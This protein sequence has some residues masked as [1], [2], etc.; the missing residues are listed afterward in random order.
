MDYNPAI[1]I[2]L[3]YSNLINKIPISEFLLSIPNYIWSIIYLVFLAIFIFYSIVLFFHWSSYRAYSPLVIVAR[4][5]YLVG[6]LAL[7]FL[8]GTFLINY[9]N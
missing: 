2:D 5:V 1:L 7:L 8:S 4:I 9:I 3:N 6:T